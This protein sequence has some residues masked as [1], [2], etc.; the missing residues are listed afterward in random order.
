MELDALILADAATVTED[1]KFFVHGG[2][3]T[4]LD[5]PELPAAI[6]IAVLARLRVQDGDLKKD[7]QLN[8][9]LIGPTGVP[10]VEPIN[11]LAMPPEAEPNLAEG[12]E[13]FLNVALTIPAMAVRDGLYHVELRYNGKLIRRVPLPVVVDKGMLQGIEPP[14]AKPK[15]SKTKRPPPPP[16]KKR[17][18]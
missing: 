15:T 18:P 8:F 13:Q 16:R 5:V 9:A 7:H 14:K 10:N 6:P 2:G 11:V 17:R 1:G 3:F 12:Q 4:R